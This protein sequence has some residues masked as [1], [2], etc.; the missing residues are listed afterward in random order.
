MPIVPNTDLAHLT[1]GQYP[2]PERDEKH[3]KWLSASVEI[4][5]GSGT[6]IYYNPADGYAYIQSCGHVFT[7]RGGSM[8]AQQSAGKKPTS[9]IT[10]W[11]HNSQKLK[12]PRT[13][14]AEILYYAYLSAGDDC[15]LLRFKPDWKPSYFPIAKADFDFESNMRLHSLGCDYRQEVAHYDVRYVRTE[16]LSYVTTENSPRPGRSGGGLMTDDHFVGICWGTSRGDG[17]GVGYFTTLKTLRGYNERNG[18]GWLNKIGVLS[19]RR[20][21]VIDRNNP[22]G[23]YAFDYIPLPQP[24]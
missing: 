24:D 15:S 23:R 14:T 13:Y 17:T 19:A 5:G 20:I 11:Y 1:S 3:R 4:G 7:N 10:V 6:I 21:P 8:T 18:F 22:Q 9:T 2:V 16:G 12:Q